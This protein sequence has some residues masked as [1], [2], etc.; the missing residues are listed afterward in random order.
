[1]FNCSANY[2]ARPLHEC[3]AVLTHPHGRLLFLLF[4]LNLRP[5]F[6]IICMNTSLPLRMLGKKQIRLNGYHRGG[7]VGCIQISICN[8]LICSTHSSLVLAHFCVR[9]L[10]SYRLKSTPAISVHHDILL[11]SLSLSTVLQL[12]RSSSPTK[13]GMKCS[14]FISSIQGCREAGLIQRLHKGSVLIKSNLALFEI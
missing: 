1:M 2:S 5:F 8:L 9:S 10:D 12:S 3:C 6:I 4:C 7:H 14:L 11:H 13:C